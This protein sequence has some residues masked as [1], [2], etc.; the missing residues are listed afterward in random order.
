[1]RAAAT[2]LLATVLTAAGCWSGPVVPVEIHK[3]YPPQTP[4]TSPDPS[5]SRVG[6]GGPGELSILLADVMIPVAVVKTHAAREEYARPGKPGEAVESWRSLADRLYRE[7]P[8]AGVLVVYPDARRRAI[9]PSDAAGRGL[10]LVFLGD[11]ERV[12]AT[13]TVTLE[14]SRTL[15]HPAAPFRFILVLRPDRRDLPSLGWRHRVFVD[16]AVREGVE[17]EWRPLRDPPPRRITVKGVPL[18]VEIADSPEKRS[19]GL[20]Y[21]HALPEDT[22]MLFIYP[23]DDVHSFWMVNTR[24]ALDVAYLDA[25][26]VIRSIRRLE[27]HDLK[28]KSSGEPVRMA[29]EVPAGWF[30]RHGVRVGDR[31]DVGA[32]GRE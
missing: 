11:D 13:R 22:G 1:M 30:E 24:I 5:R 4:H 17:P 25:E 6:I 16:P 29:L 7:A 19:M 31:V 20:M 32:D 9:A 21:R 27:P 15:V 18:E 10:Q 2:L 23:E 3:G 8:N 12:V 26:G 28:G 14:G